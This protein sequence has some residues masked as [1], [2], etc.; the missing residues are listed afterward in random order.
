VSYPFNQVGLDHLVVVEVPFEINF[1][2]NRLAARFFGDFS[3]NLDGAQR[4]QEAASAYSYILSQAPSTQNALPHSFAAQTHDV[5]AY[6]FGFGIGS[7]NFAAGPAQGVV[8]GTS[9][10]KHAW[11]IR[12]YWQH[13]EQYALDPNLIDS[14]FFEGREN[15]EGIYV[16]AAYGL[17]DNVIA[18]IRYGHA[19]RI[20]N[21]LGTGGSNQDIPQ[22]NPIA[23]YDLLQVDL[24][25]KF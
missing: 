15:L 5:K 20:N 17:T 19:G 2:I 16:A 14:D 12:T 25:F 1:K 11:E 6:Q 8:Y 13:I 18:T 10:R 24:T 4:A 3:Y 21:Q 9:S 22:V 7:T 23:S